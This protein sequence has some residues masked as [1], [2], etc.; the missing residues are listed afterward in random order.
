M[1]TFLYNSL[2]KL[3]TYFIIKMYVVYTMLKNTK[4]E[5]QK[6]ILIVKMQ[7]KRTGE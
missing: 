5:I 4:K 6:C 7:S 3:S 2:T 1:N